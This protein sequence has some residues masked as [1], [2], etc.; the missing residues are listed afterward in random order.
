MIANARN[1][2]VKTSKSVN[3]TTGNTS[4][5]YYIDDVHYVAFDDV[6]G[7]VIQVADLRIPDWIPDLSK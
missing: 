2:P 1:N 4:T 7:K 3:R 5:L 6:T